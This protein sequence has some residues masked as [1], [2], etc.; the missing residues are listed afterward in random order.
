MK[1]KLLVAVA[2]IFCLICAFTSCKLK[3]SSNTNQNTDYT[4]V[5][6]Y[7]FDSNNNPTFV[8]NNAEELEDAVTTIQDCVFSVTYRTPAPVNDSTDE[9]E[10][11]II[12]G[13]SNRAITK[14][15]YIYLER[16]MKNDDEVAY[17]IYSDG[18]SVAIAFDEDRYHIN[19]AAVRAAEAFSAT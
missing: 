8:C 7:I 3:N 19:A 18:S 15:A 2:L 13:P 5:E 14:K 10:H 4:N 16:L 17:L 9:A 6:N 1:Q 11:E 12:L